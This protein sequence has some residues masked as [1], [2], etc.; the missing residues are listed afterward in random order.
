MGRA[1]LGG[2]SFG[3]RLVTG[4]IQNRR[5]MRSAETGICRLRVRNEVSK[6]GDPADQG[7]YPDHREHADRHLAAFGPGRRS[8]Q[9]S[10][11]L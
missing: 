11:G 10:H 2:G 8:S 3:N 9:R 6:G 5:K 7:K 1:D 4:G